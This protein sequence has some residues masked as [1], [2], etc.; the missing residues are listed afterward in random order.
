MAAKI[1]CICGIWSELM[2]LLLMTTLMQT[3]QLIVQDGAA[4][5]T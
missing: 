3:V 5:E 1:M 2:G 4:N